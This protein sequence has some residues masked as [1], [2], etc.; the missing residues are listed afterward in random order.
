MTAAEVT[1]GSARVT[2]DAAWRLRLALA[3]GPWT[4][5][6][7]AP[8]Y[9]EQ[10]RRADA[11]ARRPRPARDR[12]RSQGA[13]HA[14]S[15]DVQAP[16]APRGSRGAFPSA[17]QRPDRRRRPRQHLPRHPDPAR[18]GGHRRA[19][20]PHLRARRIARREPHH[21]GRRRDPQPLPAVRP[22]QRV[23][24]GDGRALRVLGGRLRRQ[25]RRPPLVAAGG[26]EPRRRP[27]SERLAGSSSRQ[28]H[29]RQRDPRRASCPSGRGR[30]SS[31]RAA[32]TTT[33]WPSAS[34]TRTCPRSATCSSRRPGSR[35]TAR[36]SRS[37]ACAA[38]RTATATSTG[39]VPGEKGD[40]LLGVRNDLASAGLRGARSAAALRAR[41]LAWYD[42]TQP[43]RRRRQLPQRHPARQHARCRT[44]CRSTSIA[45]RAPPRDPRLLRAPGGVAAAWAR[46][47]SSTPGFECT[48]CAPASRYIFEGQRNPSAANGSSVRGG[49]GL[50]DV[51]DERERLRARRR[52]D[53]GPL[54]DLRLASPSCPACA[55]TRAA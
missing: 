5:T 3:P 2:T 47:T 37:P 38:A 31:P 34:W 27:T 36:S 28:P 46:G 16:P 39:D 48:S 30:G 12:A 1:A 49:A 44:T 7:T 17:A 6:V 32:P 21:H 41:S 11:S 22:H 55:S 19:R 35:A 52:M 26:G 53:R 43:L 15:V 54:P 40:F 25:P 42:N 9:L 24:P 13:L 20:Q 14:S 4:L 23:Q 50:P 18:R 10:T 51:F 29:R 45:L 8:G 33:S